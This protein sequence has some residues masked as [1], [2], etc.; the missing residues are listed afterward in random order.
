MLQFRS[1]LYVEANAAALARMVLGYLWTW[2]FKTGL[3]KQQVLDWFL[4]LLHCDVDQPRRADI[5]PTDLVNAIARVMAGAEWNCGDFV[6]ALEEALDNPVA[7]YRW[8]AGK[9]G[10][11]V[12]VKVHSDVGEHAIVRGKRF[13][14]SI[15]IGTWWTTQEPKGSANQSLQRLVRK[16]SGAVFWNEKRKQDGGRQYGAFVIVDRANGEEVANQL[17]TTADAADLEGGGEHR[18]SAISMAGIAEHRDVRN[19]DQVWIGCIRS[20]KFNWR[21]SLP[22]LLNGRIEEFQKAKPYRNLITQLRER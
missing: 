7:G 12:L 2:I 21:Y 17:C 15:F 3:T 4:R 16:N 19:S 1:A 13:A 10:H 5:I 6:V 9:H 14:D 18:L 22:D 8:K 20:I 11:H